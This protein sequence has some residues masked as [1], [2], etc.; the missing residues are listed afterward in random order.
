MK[1]EAVITIPGE[2]QSQ[3]RHRDG[4]YGGKYDPS[5]GAKESFAVQCLAQWRPDGL[6]S[7]KDFEVDVSFYCGGQDKDSDNMYKL[8]TDAL[9]GLYWANDRQIKNHHVHVIDNS[10][11]PRTVLMI[12]FAE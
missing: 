4:K 2:P 11:N 9:Q 7:N 10:D 6:P 1:I 8:I 3:K 12:G 5:A